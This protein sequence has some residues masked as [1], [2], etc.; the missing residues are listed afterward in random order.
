MDLT[1]MFTKIPHRGGQISRLEEAGQSAHPVDLY[2]KDGAFRMS[3][4]LYH[5]YA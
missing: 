1:Y 5:G 4:A 3:K 2:M